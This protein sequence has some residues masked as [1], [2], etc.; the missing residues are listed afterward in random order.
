VRPPIETVAPVAR[1]LVAE[2]VW[3]LR[4]LVCDVL[5]R[6]RDLVVVA[7]ATR[8]EEAFA[9]TESLRPDVVLLDYVL[10][11]ADADALVIGV[12]ARAPGAALVGFSG[13][14]PEILS[15]DARRRLTSHVDKTVSLGEVAAAVRAAALRHALDAPQCRSPAPGKR[16][17][18]VPPPGAAIGG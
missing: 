17:Q 12:H 13:Y 2:D 7:E 9:L 1:V 14:D 16:P 15:A 4:R 10:P 6:H 18:P 5:G 8:A 3:E 11:G